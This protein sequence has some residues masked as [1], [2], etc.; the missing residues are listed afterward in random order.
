MSL[1]LTALGWNERR[2]SEFAPYADR[3][4]V[5]ARVSL[6]HTHIYRVLTADGERLARVAGRLRHRAGARSDFPAVGDWVAAELDPHGGD[7]TIQDI[8]PRTSRFSRRAAGD[9]TEE[10]IV[11]ANIDTVFLVAGLDGDFNPRRLERYLVVAWESGAT[12]VIVLNK[13]DLHADPEARGDEVRALAPAVAVHVV[14]CLVP[15]TLDPLRAHLGHG[16]TAA[17]LGSS[18]AGKSTIVNRLVGRDLLRTSDV[19]VWDSRGRHTSTAR[20]LVILPADGVLIDTPGLREIQLWETSGALADTFADVD[21]LAEACRFRDCRHRSEPG[22]AV[23]AAVDAGTLDAGRLAS[24]HKLQDEQE[25]QS[26]QQEE[27]FRLEEKRRGRIGAK[28][29]RKHLKDKGRTT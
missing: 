24:F 29:L 9:P 25:H 8:L 22:C 20:Q 6:E 19:R 4:L 16:R 26:R 17:L 3:G 12:P 15:G 2:A 23:R 18:G 28:A 13:S 5:P 7:A 10:Q 11:A 14:S 27:R 21:A 1:D